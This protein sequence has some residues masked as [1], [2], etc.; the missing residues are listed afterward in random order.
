M[1]S[2]RADV[3]AV[4]AE[5]MN[6]EDLL[7]LFENSPTNL[8]IYGPAGTGKSTFIQNLRRHTRKRLLVL[9]PT[10][11]AALNVD[12]RTI[13]SAIALAPRD[14]FAE[15]EVHLTAR[16]EKLLKKVDG[17]VIDEVSMVR[18]DILDAIDCLCRRA[19]GNDQPFG[20]I[21]L[22]LI[23]DPCQLPPI[24]GEGVRATFLQR[25]GSGEPQFFDAHAFRDGNFHRVALTKIYRQRDGEFVENLDRIRRSREVDRAI[26]YFNGLVGNGEDGREK[27]V[28]IVARRETADRIN[29]ERLQALPGKTIRYVA[30][31]DGCFR[32][33]KDLPAPEILELRVGAPVIFCKNNGATWVN[34]TLG[35]VA[36]LSRD[37]I[38]VRV[39]GNAVLPVT[40]E[41]WQSTDERAGTYVQFPLQIAYALTVHRVQ[42]LTL[43]R[44]IVNLEGGAF[45]GGQLYVALSRTRDPGGLF[46]D[47]KI[48]RSDVRISTRTAKFFAR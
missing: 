41:E 37:R 9:A 30:A 26:A 28:T 14:H 33:K 31:K 15:G 29:G 39:A 16:T 7:Q 42:G 43:D 45:T 17:M 44:V 23:G 5:E 11:I 4:Q 34:G 2:V 12:G 8:L 18:P 25:Y 20:G 22:L 13:H 21:Q 38:D 1:P 48:Q 10:G 36:K 47:R 19:R 35:T 27:A 3:L 40:R 6:L 46:L 24:I 32:G